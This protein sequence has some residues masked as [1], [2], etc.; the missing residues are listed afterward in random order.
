MPNTAARM[1]GH[2]PLRAP[3]PVSSMDWMGVPYSEMISA[4]LFSAKAM[5]SYTARAMCRESW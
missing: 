5:P 2:R 3:P 4:Q 1:S